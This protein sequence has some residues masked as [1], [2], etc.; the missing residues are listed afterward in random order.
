MSITSSL[1]EPLSSLPLTLYPYCVDAQSLLKYCWERE[2][3][4]SPE[5]HNDLLWRREL[6]SYNIYQLD[7]LWPLRVIQ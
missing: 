2:W 7:F 4:A 5:G 1:E 6:T 3:V